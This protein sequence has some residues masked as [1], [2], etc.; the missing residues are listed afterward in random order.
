MAMNIDYAFNRVREALEERENS[1]EKS[2][3]LTK[4]DEC[5]MWAE[6]TTITKEALEREGM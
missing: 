4:L 3:A 1:R 6:R 5:S 2:L